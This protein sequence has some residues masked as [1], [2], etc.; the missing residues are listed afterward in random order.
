MSSPPELVPVPQGDGG[1][2][3]DAFPFVETVDAL[4]AEELERD[5]KDLLGQSDDDDDDDFLDAL[6]REVRHL[7]E[8][9]LRADDFAAPASPRSLDEAREKVERA[10]EEYEQRSKSEE[11]TM[12]DG[13]K[14]EDERL[15]SEDELLE[16]A[17]AE[18]MSKP[19]E[20]EEE[21]IRR[22]N[23]LS[24][25]EREVPKSCS[26]CKG[27][28][29]NVIPS[30]AGQCQPCCPYHVLWIIITQPF[31]RVSS[32][33]AA[34]SLTLKPFIKDAGEFVFGHHPEVPPVAF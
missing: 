33:L 32:Q 8:E 19:S 30:K 29:T 26:L 21:R 20:E 2:D 16:D 12:G 23:A 9:G 18:E 4:T 10:A 5:T 34:F 17:V 7:E 28:N 1:D 3:E 11:K 14:S 13:L 22:E 6:D 25:K 15:K 27:V 24:E 31:H